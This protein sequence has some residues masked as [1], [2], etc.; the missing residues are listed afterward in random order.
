MSQ[1]ISGF[2]MPHDPLIA[3]MPDA[4]PVE[5]RDSCMNAY[6]DIVERV[7][8]QNID[9]VIIIGD[10]HYTVN[11]PYCVPQAMIGI[12]DV[13][14]PKEPWLGI[15]REKIANNESLA[16]H[17]MD[18]GHTHQVDWAAS[19][20]LIVDHSIA[21]PVEYA[22]KPIKDLKIVP[23]YINSGVEPFINSKRAYEIGLSIKAAINSWSG[24]E[25]IAVYGTGGISHWPGMA[26]MGSVNEAWDR[27]IIDLICKG[28]VDELIAMS[29][30]EILREG[31]NGGL[32]IKNFICAMGILDGWTGEEIAYEAVPEWV[33][34]CG[35]L[36]MKIK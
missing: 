33:C 16:K 22:V 24:N 3:A 18:Y 7:K 1:I 17:I 23:I 29:D 9:T 35:Y 10:D 13:E 20:T 27:K 26:Q 25:R 6:K 5:K 14:G 31:G 4:P 30:E 11:G 28:N 2:L 21:I 8:E 12:G 15:P 34:G 19:K 32:E 36:E